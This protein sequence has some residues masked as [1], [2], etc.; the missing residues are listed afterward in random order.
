MA[1]MKIGNTANSQPRKQSIVEV[2]KQ[3]P[4]IEKSKLDIELLQI[5]LLKL[6]AK[7]NELKN[8][9]HEPIIK[10]ADIVHKTVNVTHEVISSKDTKARKYSKELRKRSN[11]QFEIVLNELDK[12]TI[13]HHILQT[14]LERINQKPQEKQLVTVEKHTETIKEIQFKIDKRILMLIGISMLINIGLIL[15]L[16]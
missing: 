8:Q 10:S 3:N 7:H 11:N 9:K 15:A 5:E 6:S 16:K 14:E 2:I 1:K 13:K 4:D 12:L